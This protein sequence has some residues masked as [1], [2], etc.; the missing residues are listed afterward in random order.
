MKYRAVRFVPTTPVV[1]AILLAATAFADERAFEKKIEI[2]AFPFSF[3]NIPVPITASFDGAAPVVVN[4]V[5]EEFY[6]DGTPI[7]LTAPE[8]FEH[9]PFV[10]W[11][12]DGPTVYS[13][14]RTISFNLDQSA[15][16]IAAYGTPTYTLNVTSSPEVGI[17][18]LNEDILEMQTPYERVFETED[19]YEAI[20]NAPVTFNGKPFAR[21]M[22]NGKEESKLHVINVMMDDDYDLEAQYGS[23]SITCKIQPKEARRKARWRIDGGEWMKRGVTVEDLLVGKYRIEW[24]PVAGFKTPN[25]RNVPIEDGDAHTIRGRYFPEE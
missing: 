12:K 21:W 9:R 25:P 16:Y 2:S 17:T 1:F 23:G 6:D 11:W 20:I 14:E 5:Y 10:A 15:T 19:I 24:K 7:V 22:L 4:T 18:F 8:T 13:E 3:D